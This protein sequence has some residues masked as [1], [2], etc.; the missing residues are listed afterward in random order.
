M[1]D[2]KPEAKGTPIDLRYDPGSMTMSHDSVF[3]DLC[4]GVADSGSLKHKWGEPKSHMDLSA[5]PSGL[6]GD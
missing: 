1:S 5:P 6:K 2:L 3:K 4:P